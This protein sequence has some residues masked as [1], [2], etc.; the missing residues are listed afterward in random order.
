M[1]GGEGDSWRE[2]ESESSSSLVT[3]REEGNLRRNSS[4]VNAPLFHDDELLLRVVRGLPREGLRPPDEEEERGVEGLEGKEGGV[5]GGKE[6]RGGEVGER[7][8]RLREGVA[9]YG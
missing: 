8:P 9:K 4:N 3:G 1:G 7:A 5:A 6:D 2:S